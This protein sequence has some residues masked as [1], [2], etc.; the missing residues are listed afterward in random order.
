MQ[1]LM[2]VLTT[3]AKSKSLK[4]AA[5]A[6]DMNYS[7]LRDYLGNNILHDKGELWSEAAN[8]YLTANIRDQLPLPF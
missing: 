8:A 5:A 2:S 4:D 3:V 6:L 7:D 1:N